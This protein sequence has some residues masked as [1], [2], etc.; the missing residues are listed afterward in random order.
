MLVGKDNVLEWPAGNENRYTN[1]KWSC[2]LYSD[3]RVCYID[4]MMLKLKDCI[5]HVI[6]ADLTKDNRQD[7]VK[8]WKYFYAKLNHQYYSKIISGIFFCTDDLLFSTYWEGPS[9]CSGWGHHRPQWLALWSASES[10]LPRPKLPNPCRPSLAL[11]HISEQW[12]NYI[13][14]QNSQK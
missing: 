9:V 5:F 3:T 1:Y 10:A 2:F 4:W 6:H 8:K 7:V 14:I 12:F 13:A 11:L